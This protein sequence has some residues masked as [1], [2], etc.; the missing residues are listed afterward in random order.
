MTLDKTQSRAIPAR[1]N[2]TLF[3]AGTDLASAAP[4]W[5]VG[6]LPGWLTVD[7]AA[8]S[9][10]LPD[11]ESGRLSTDWQL[12]LPVYAS[13]EGL[14]EK[15]EPYT[16][17]LVIAVDAQSDASITVPVTA[18]VQ[19]EPVAAD[20]TWGLVTS[21]A[22]C[23]DPAEGV[24]YSNSVYRRGE[25]VLLE[26]GGEI[27]IP[28]QSCDV[29]RIPCASAR[30]MAVWRMASMRRARPKLSIRPL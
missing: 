1:R 12:D 20:S 25:T 4:T 2:V 11:V 27:Y 24:A 19:A 28:F 23:A 26:L 17:D 5:S 7:T 8:A 22:T 6:E 10:H 9:I 14:P 16:A 15:T 18:Y 13:P 29:D 3:L 30:G 21:P